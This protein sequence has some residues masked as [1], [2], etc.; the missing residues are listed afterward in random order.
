MKKTF[1]T[2]LILITLWINVA[3]QDS[4]KKI[5][6]FRDSTDHAYDISDWL[7]KKQGFLLVPVLIT[8]PAVGYGAAAAAVIFHSSYSEKNGPPSM[9]GVLGGGTENGT[10]MT[11]VFHVGYWRQDRLRY[12]GAVDRALGDG[13]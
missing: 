12:M 8:E 1:Q 6:V 10:W 4:I 13:A 9:T 7:L 3:A 11:G 5:S 2:I